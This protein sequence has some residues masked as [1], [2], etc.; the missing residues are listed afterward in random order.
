VNSASGWNFWVANNATY[1]RY[2]KEGVVPPCAPG[3]ESTEY[4]QDYRAL[5]A[6]IRAR[7]LQGVERIKEEERIAWDHGLEFMREQ[8][9]EFVKSAVLKFLRLWSPFPDAVTKGKAQGGAA[10]DVI[11]AATYIPLFVFGIAGLVLAARDHWRRLL[12]IYAFIGIFVAPFA[13]FLPT[14]RYR[15]PIDFLFAIFAS[16]ALVRAWAFSFRWRE[17]TRVL[18]AV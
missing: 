7:G 8:P 2:G 6:S 10:R 17:R 14:T 4:C 16:Y 18:Q 13:I 11:G 15:L 9:G 5:S 3:Y 12:P 1:A